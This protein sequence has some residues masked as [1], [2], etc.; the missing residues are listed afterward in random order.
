MLIK[1][2]SLFKLALH[3]FDDRK[4]N[5]YLIISKLYGGH[6]M[7]ECQYMEAGISKCSTAAGISNS[8]LSNSVSMLQ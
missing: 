6:L 8:L 3:L 2:Q 1:D 4:S 5:E 7:T